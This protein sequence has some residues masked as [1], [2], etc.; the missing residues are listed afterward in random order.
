MNILLIQADQQRRDSI[1]PY[2]N[3]IA[4]TPHLD[5]LAAEGITFD[6]AFTPIPICAPARASLIT[7]KRPVRH[8]I[9]RN[10]ESGAVGGRDFIGTHPM[11]AQR[12]AQQGYRSTLCGKWHVGTRLTPADCGFDGV[13][14]PGYGY[15]AD[16]P[17]YLDYLH[18]LGC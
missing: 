16:H 9:L 15:P 5:R 1:G 18:S 3:A 17:H 13:F 11:L 14:Y 7:G 6:N 12:L 2:G 4:A 10:L 8:G